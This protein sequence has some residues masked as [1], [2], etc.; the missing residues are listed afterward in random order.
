MKHNAEI[1]LEAAKGAWEMTKKNMFTEKAQR[2]GI[3]RFE[4]GKLKTTIEAV[5]NGLGLKRMPTNEDIAT[6]QFIPQQ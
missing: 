2:D 4:A 1:G 6:N 3:G 5:Y